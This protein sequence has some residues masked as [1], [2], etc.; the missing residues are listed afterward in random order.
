MKI[1][2]TIVIAVFM[3]IN[4]SAFAQITIN[5]DLSETQYITISTKQNTNSGFGPN[6][7]VSKIVYYPDFTNSILYLGVE[8]KLNTS[9]NDGIGIWINISGTG[10]PAG[11]SAGTALAFSGG[12]HYMG[13]NGMGNPNFKA[14]FEVDYMFA[15]NPGSLASNCFVDAGSRVGSAAGVYIGNCGLAGSSLDYSTTGTVFSNGYTISFAFNNA[16]TSDKGFEIKIPFDAI[17]ATAAMNITAFAFVVSSTAFFSDVTVPGN[18]TGGNPG[19]DPD[20]G[21][22]SGG[23]YNSGGYPLP[24]ELTSFN[25][26]VIDNNVQLF[27]TTATETNN[28]GFEIERNVMVHSDHNNKWEIIGFVYGSGNSNSPKSY[29]F[30][31]KNPSEGKV[32]Y[33]LKQIDNDGTFSYS[34]V[35]EVEFNNVLPKEFTLYQ[36]YPNPFNPSTTIEFSLPEKSEVMLSIFNLLGEKVRELLNGSMEAG[37]QR[38]VFDARELPSGTYVYQIN[39]KG[40]TKSFI[41]SKKMTLVK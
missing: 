12:G 3:L 40:S 20:F 10:A 39:A 7:D 30:I 21:V 34:N 28:Y 1:S 14:D 31:D 15:I 27:W 26:S 13:G 29:S 23:Q 36:N 11:A 38:V 41:Q 17:G 19:F 35:V 9:S 16:G 2:N 32:Y 8:G 18:R 5:G 25:A 33:R 24:V 6:I 22:I 4:L 37:Y